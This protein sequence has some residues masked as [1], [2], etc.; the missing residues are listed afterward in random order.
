MS[1]Q[2]INKESLYSHV[3]M[4]HQ[5]VFLF[6]DTLRRNI[7]MYGDY[8]DEEVLSAVTKAG[9]TGVLEHLGGLDG[10]IEENGRNLSGG[11]QQ[12]VAIARA[13]IRGTDIMLVDKAT[14]SLDTQTS[15]QIND[16]LM[17]QKDLTLVAV[18]HRT[19]QESLEAY[20]EVLVLEQGVLLE[21]APYRQL[22]AE[23]RRLLS[24]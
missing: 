19:D 21:H 15:K 2:D 4:I 3:S 11:E 1:L 16:V 17:N 5:K 22:S 8:S 18:T 24:L 23:R 13:F 20:D 6:E 10:R 9:L 14:A 12:R 7:T